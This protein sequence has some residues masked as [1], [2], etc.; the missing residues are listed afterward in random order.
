MSKIVVARRPVAMLLATFMVIGA[1]A[2]SIARANTAD[3]TI[4]SPTGMYANGALLPTGRLVDPAGR[5]TP[6]GDFPEA[7]T[8]SPAGDIAVVSNAG[9]G[10]GSNPQQGN[11]TLQVIDLA[12]EQVV[13]TIADHAKGQDT[14]YNSGVTFSPD[15]KHVYV[16]GGGNDA[17]YDY[18]VANGR[19]RLVATWI[20]T[21]KHGLPLLPEVMDI[22][23]YS[24][25]VAVAP[26]GKTIYVT[27][28]QGGSVTALN[29]TSGAIAWE[30]QLPGVAGIGPAPA[31][32]ALSSDG[33]LAYVTAQGHNAVFV[34]DTATG[35]VRGSV[36]V[37]DYLRHHR[38]SLCAAAL[39]QET[40]YAERRAVVGP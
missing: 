10:E 31:G 28:E 38:R 33:S 20:T 40:Q 4:T 2:L 26:N 19:L 23:G 22:Y 8:I 12:S 24:K 32:L 15:A 21:R 25:G 13:Q 30:T 11:Q 36:P 29:T 16:T 6:L 35:L 1:G 27:N 39:A 5:V 9:Q 3:A 7:I 17:V 34:L 14:F 37:G 18:A